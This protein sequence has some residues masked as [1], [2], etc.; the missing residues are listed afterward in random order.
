MRQAARA[1]LGMGLGVLLMVAWALA[2]LYVTDGTSDPLRAPDHT[3]LP[4]LMVIAASPFVQL[5]SVSN[6]PFVTWS[7]PVRVAVNFKRW[8]HAV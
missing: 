3:A 2:V 7:S 1:A 6:V 4:P 8:D 5:V